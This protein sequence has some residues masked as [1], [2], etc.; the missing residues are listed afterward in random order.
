VLDRPSKLNA[1]T[2]TMLRRILELSVELR[3]LRPRVVVVRSTSSRAF[4]VGADIAEQ[5]RVTPADAYG[6]SELGSL[7]FDAIATL[8]CPVVGQI[9]GHCLGGGFELALACDIRIG[10]SSTRMSFPETGLGNSPAWGGSTRLAQLVGPSLAME[11]MLTGETIDASRGNSLGL[12]NHVAPGQ[13]SAAVNEFCNVLA[14]KAPI[15]QTAVK[16]SVQAAVGAVRPF[17]DAP[18]ASFQ[19]TTQDS[20]EGKVAFANPGTTT[21]FKGL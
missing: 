8:P 7:A 10:D 2:S 11:L 1:L 18:H 6:L 19:S 20:R 5:Q 16:R 21:K 3:H 14:S 12:L 4:C 9:N 13:L 15:A 17:H